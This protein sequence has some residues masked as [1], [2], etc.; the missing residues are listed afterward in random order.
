MMAT[1]TQTTDGPRSRASLLPTWWRLLRPH[2][3]TAAFVP[4]FVGT[5]LAAAQGAFRPL[6]F[7][8]MLAA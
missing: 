1:T 5:A 8:A 6:P 2:T 7:L 4:V 3:L